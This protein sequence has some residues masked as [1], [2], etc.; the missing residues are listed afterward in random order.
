[1]NATPT[2][3]DE[4]GGDTDDSDQTTGSPKADN[5]PIQA[6]QDVGDSE[7]IDESDETTTEIDASDIQ[8]HTY[9]ATLYAPLFYASKE[10]SVIETNPTI[11]ATA[12]LHAIGY[13]YYE[14]SRA[15]ALVG[16]KATTP[17]YTHLCDLPFFVSEMVP[18]EDHVVDERTFRTV[19]YTTERAVVSQDKSVG[20]YLT[21]SGNP[22][23]RSFEGS[24]AGWHKV[25][26]FTGISP[27]TEF[28]FTL[29]APAD[30]TP[31]DRLGFRAGINR[32]GE[33]RA[34]RNDTQAETITLN[35]Y[36]L[37]SVYDL[38]DELICEVMDHADDFE[39]GNDPR[40]NRFVGVDADWA[41]E[42]V[43]PT[44]L[45]KGDSTTT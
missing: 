40:T 43:M 44:L 31:P 19:S 12:L 20:E 16:E 38:S 8:P 1:M 24:R 7:T 34:E 42:E 32:S 9:T 17:D 30:E 2:T 27:G 13:E 37:Q 21:G 10:G 41:T 5:T 18:T 3:L 33:L 26:K 23:P 36:L 4:F 45:N 22:V 35:Q 39:R 25:R 6:D 11:S 29:W 15:F 28:T 14:L